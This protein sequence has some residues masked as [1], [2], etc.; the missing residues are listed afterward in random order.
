MKIKQFLL[1]GIALFAV[2]CSKDDPEPVLDKDS[3][4][5]SLAEEATVIEPP[6]AMA[7]SDNQYAQEA[8]GYIQLVNGIAEYLNFIELIPNNAEKSTTKITA[9]NGRVKA[10]GQVVTY[11]WTD[12]QSG[13]SVAYQIGETS[14]SYTFEFFF[15]FQGEAEWTKYF[16]GSEKKDRSSGY[17]KVYDVY[18]FYDEARGVL[19]EY[20]WTRSGNILDFRMEDAYGDFVIEISINEE[21]K[22]GSATYIIYGNVEYE[23]EWDAEGNGSWVWYDEEG[24]IIEEGTWVVE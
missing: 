4:T 14:D 19:I 10:P 24:N 2:S 22:A 17:L 12:V 9:S 1:L 20:S 16:D 8:V 15:K 23:M 3:V 13:Y 21:T 18:G 7:A 5:L 6:A 11:T